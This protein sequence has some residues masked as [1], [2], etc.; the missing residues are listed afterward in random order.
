MKS[1]K[2]TGHTMIIPKTGDPGGSLLGSHLGVHRRHYRPWNHLLRNL[3]PGH[4]GNRPGIFPRAGQW[5]SARK[6]RLLT[7]G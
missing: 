5:F 7:T 6:R 4:L 3:S 2:N 1:E